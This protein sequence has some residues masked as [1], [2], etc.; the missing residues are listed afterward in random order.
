VSGKQ[1]TAELTHTHGV[2]VCVLKDD[3]DGQRAAYCGICLD[4]GYDDPSDRLH[5]DE[6]REDWTGK[7][8]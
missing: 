7:S 4:D 5:W 6:Q 8:A 2:S 3:H 1:C